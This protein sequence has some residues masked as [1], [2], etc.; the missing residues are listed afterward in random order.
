MKDKKRSRNQARND[1]PPRPP[2]AKHLWTYKDIDPWGVQRV[3]A[4]C[5]TKE[6]WD[7]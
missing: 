6:Q 7:T 5:H 3:C 2:C 1:A 4:I